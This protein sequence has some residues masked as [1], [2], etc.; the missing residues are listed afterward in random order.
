MK[1]TI[2]LTTVSVALALFPLVSV[3]QQ[4]TPDEKAK[5]QLEGFLSKT[6]R[7]V[8]KVFHPLGRVSGQYSTSAELDAAII[9]EP[10]NKEKG[11]RGIRINVKGGDVWRGSIPHSLTWTNWTP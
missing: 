9:Y 10:G 1:K 4:I 7:L 8:I 5:T 3:A 6:G 2:C 11:Q